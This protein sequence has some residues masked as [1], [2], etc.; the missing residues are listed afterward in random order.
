MSKCVLGIDIAKLKF[1]VA[2][3]VGDKYKTKIFDNTS[4]G[5]SALEEWLDR[6]EANGVHICMEATGIYGDELGYYLVDKGYKVSIINP[7]QIKGFGQSE[8]VRTKT[9]KTDSKLIARF[10]RALNPPLWHPIPENVRELRSLTKRLEALQKMEREELNRL[11]VSHG[12]AKDSINKAA[13]FLATEISFIKKLINN[14]INSDPNF[15]ANKELLETIPGVGENTIA[16]IL[17]RQCTPERFGSAKQL[18][19][20]A[21][22]NPKHHRSG[23][24]VYGRSCISKTGDS[25]FRKALYMP[26]IVAKRHN[27]VLKAFYERLLA[28]GKPK[29]LAV[30]AVMRKLLHLIYG[31]LKSK[32]P[33]DVNI[34]LALA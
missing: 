24:S 1:D 19:A 32:K 8:L 13:E 17:S 9:D 12:Y 5:H 14:L 20:F 31:V 4:Q 27:S 23:T 18:A 29:M 33:F 28:D 11:D 34:H 26:A 30:C 3:L 7:A 21:G 2:L 25:C 16:Q 22:L 15:R 10:C 6:H